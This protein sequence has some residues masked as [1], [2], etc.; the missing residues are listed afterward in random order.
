M[1]DIATCPKCG[2]QLGLPPSTDATDRVECPECHAIF[3]LAETVQIT[4]PVARLL[5]AEESQFDPPELSGNAQDTEPTSTSAAPI[6]TADDHCGDTPQPS[7]EERLKRALALDCSEDAAPDEAINSSADE[8]DGSIPDKIEATA[9]PTFDFQLD[10]PPAAEPFAPDEFEVA[11]PVPR[12]DTIA[13]R[14]T[15]P[16]TPSAKQPVKTLA[17][18]AASAVSAATEET[19]PSPESTTITTSASADS[20]VEVATPKKAN[21]Q[22]RRKASRGFPKIA[23]FV[24]GPIAGS[25]LGLYGLLWLQGEQGDHLGLSRVLPTAMLPASFRQTDDQVE[26]VATDTDATIEE[27]LAKQDGP[28][29]PSQE[30]KQDSSV[31]L[32]S[33]TRHLSPP[34]ISASQFLELVD[35]AA[36]AV[37]EFVGSEM[38]SQGSVKRKGQAYMKICQLAEHFDFIQQLGLAPAVDAQTRAATRLMQDLLAD[39]SAREELAHIASRWWEYD[40]RPNAGIVFVGQVQ[41]TESTDVGTLCWLQLGETTPTIPVLVS[42]DGFRTGDRVG[43]VGRVIAAPGGLPQDFTGTQVVSPWHDFAL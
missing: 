22:G 34:R 7:W 19:P 36:Q 37:P 20:S 12:P 21:A 2:K 8:Q 30:I 18:F 9:S 38:T 31:Q 42:D 41:R 26:V 3:P 14:P 24:V 15:E 43:I 23:A 32:A 13:A 11:A 39:D 35:A 6:E 4:L 33:A 10:P 25:V 28:D 16:A 1:A 27:Q 5:P 29:S 17:D 40:K